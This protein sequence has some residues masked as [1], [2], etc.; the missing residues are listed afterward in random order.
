MRTCIRHTNKRAPSVE[1]PARACQDL[2]LTG[3]DRPGQPPEQTYAIAEEVRRWA[4][5][6]CGI[7]GDITPFQILVGP[8]QA[9]RDFAGGRVVDAPEVDLV[10]RMVAKGGIMQRLFPAGATVREVHLTRTARRLL[11]GTAY[12]RRQLLEAG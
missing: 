4:A 10:A 3:T 11:D 2:G 5:Q 9:Y 12:V 1:R 8:P 7:A 6:R